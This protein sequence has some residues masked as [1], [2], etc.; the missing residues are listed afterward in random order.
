MST[1]NRILAVLDPNAEQ[2]LAFD[3]SLELAAPLGA[4][5]VLAVCDYVEGL[6]RPVFVDEADVE[7][8]KAELV[9]RHYE[10]LAQFEEKAREQKITSQTLVMWERPQSGAILEAARKAQADL[11]VKAASDGSL[12]D[13]LLLGATDW[14]LIRESTVALWLAKRPV[15]TASG[16]WTVA[17]DPVH[18]DEK[19]IGLDGKLLDVSSRLAKDLGA[20]IRVFHAYERP[21]VLAEPSA[22][23][24]A[25][26]A[27]TSSA[28]LPASDTEQVLENRVE[29]IV[30]LARPF[31]I[32]K[33]RIDVCV[34]R[35]VPQLDRQVGTR[36]IS[37]VVLGAVARGLLDRL[38]VGNTAEKVLSN[39]DCDMLVLKPD[40][41]AESPR[42]K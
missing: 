23:G 25:A 42:K 38:I 2:Q 20:T 13:R 11:V 30:D 1:F 9:R 26:G 29:Q 19:H 32:G 28:V 18:P 24:L 7:K 37:L 21:A 17:V 8:A 10:W 3:R 31:G 6:S 4:E 36:N 41:T 34:G 35:T 27:A 15:P 33:S 16:T 12:G 40:S 22:A 39:I 14:E 5:I